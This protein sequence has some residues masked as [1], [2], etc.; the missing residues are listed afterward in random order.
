MRALVVFESMFG[1]TEKLARA[2]GDE[3]APAFAVTVC[4]VDDAPELV[5]DFDLVVV[6]APTHIHG[7]S[8]PKSRLDASTKTESDLVTQRRGPDGN[9]S[10]G[11]SRGGKPCRGAAFGTRAAKPRWM[12][13]SAARR[14]DRLLRRAGFGRAAKPEDFFVT[15]MFGPLA[16]GELERA[17][18]WARELAAMT[19]GA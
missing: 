8:R 14:A 15:G 1:N 18:A 10:S 16:A 11:V 13:G 9:G 6:G 12:T 4:N 17:R 7:L 5:E 19:V 2:I 3:L